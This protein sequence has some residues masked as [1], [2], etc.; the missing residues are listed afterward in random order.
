MTALIIVC[1]IL[2]FT[3]TFLIFFTSKA[4]KDTKELE[5]EIIKANEN[6]ENAAEITTEANKTKADAR[7]GDHE[8]DFNFMADKLHDFANK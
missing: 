1:I 7:T 2:A 6:A 8:H 4:L 5:K 3:L